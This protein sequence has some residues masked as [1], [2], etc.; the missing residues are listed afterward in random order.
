MRFPR[1]IKPNFQFQQ[2]IPARY[3][4]NMFG[5]EPGRRASGASNGAN[6]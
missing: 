4:V 2:F 6:E 3:P 1:L 5:E